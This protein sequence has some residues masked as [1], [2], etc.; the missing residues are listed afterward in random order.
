MPNIDQPGGQ[1]FIRDLNPQGAD[2]IVMIHG[3]LTNHTVFL[4]CGAFEL[5][6]NHRVT[7]YDLRGHG[8]TD[9]APTDFRL[10][11]IVGDLFTVMDTLGIAR[12]DLVGYS[13]GAAAAIQAWLADPARIGRLALIEPFGLNRRQLP[14]HDT[15]VEEGV[16][17]YS[18]ST[19]A[20]VTDR[21]IGQLEDQLTSLFD[22]HR[23]VES[24]SADADFFS[25]APLD[26]LTAP[27]LLLAG[28]SSPFLDDAE[29]AARRLP[30]ASLHTTRGDHNL[31]VT[32]PGWVRRWLT[33][34]GKEAS[35]G[36][37]RP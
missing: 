5:A 30:N 1:V 6:K 20:R 27:V 18:R 37:Q 8:L 21:R 9:L 14:T 4:K 12:A 13:F 34:W 11:T 15:T 3:L 32:R 33:R 16:A 24:L 31:P 29:L 36:Y 2:P 7:M 26:Q 22:D 25:R 28:K 10:T 23:L 19:S 17:E 35:R